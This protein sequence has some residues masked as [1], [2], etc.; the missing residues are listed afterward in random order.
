MKTLFL[1]VSLALCPFLIS[2]ADAPP[3]HPV[4]VPMGDETFTLSKPPTRIVST[5]LGADEILLDLVDSDRIVALSQ[6]AD[7][8]KYSNIVGKATPVKQRLGP[9][10][11]RVVFL[12][13]DLVFIAAYSTPDFIHLMGRSGVP[14]YQFPLPGSIED[15]RDMIRNVGDLVGEATR[16]RRI[17]L[18]MDQR[19][20][21]IG[22]RLEGVDRPSVVPYSYGYAAGSETIIGEIVELAGGINLAAERGVRG[23][24]RLPTERLLVWDPDFLLIEG[25]KAARTKGE[26]LLATETILA[27]LRAVREGQVIEVP[28]PHL[29]TVS[30]HI[31]KGI[32]DTARL[33]HPDRFPEQE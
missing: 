21:E 13:P 4:T 19:I 33:L 30:H 6:F 9:S 27:H 8:P 32:E 12:Q 2:W 23:H 14:A 1:L 11:E 24:Q 10:V 3:T 7:D 29:S 5:V 18:E 20:A 26:R 17:V 22:Q 16:A 28:T 31:V 25:P 15:I